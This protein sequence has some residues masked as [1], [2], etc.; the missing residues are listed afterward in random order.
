MVQW[1]LDIHPD[2]PSSRELSSLVKQPRLL[3]RDRVLRGEWPP[4][5]GPLVGYGTMFSMTRLR[6]HREMGR[7][8]FD[9]YARLRCSSYYRWTYDLLDRTCFLV[10]LAA[11]ASLPVERMLGSDR[12]FVRSDSNYKL[13]PAQLHSSAGLA[14]FLQ[15][16]SDYQ[17]ELAVL[18]EP[19]DIEIEFRCFCRNGH[20]VCGSSYPEAPFLPPPPEVRRRAEEV[21]ARLMLQG[22]PLLSVDL[23]ACRDGRL[24][25]V[26]VGGVNSWGLYGS[27]PEAFIAALEA[28][29][30]EEQG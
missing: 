21:A 28:Q 29:A 23:A 4:L 27:D 18:S 24:R 30:L 12:F 10:P 13:F 14:E 25:L 3:D 5:E 8:V 6:R 26:E 2:F 7:A 9:D 15:R 22:M 16:Y 11:A 20:F 1:L 17:D 19:M